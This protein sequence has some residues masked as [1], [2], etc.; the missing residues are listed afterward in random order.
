MP[1]NPQPLYGSVPYIQGVSEA[2]AQSTTWVNSAH[3]WIDI[4]D[5]TMGETDGKY[6]TYL[7][8][9]GSL[10]VFMFASTTSSENGFNR[11]KKVQQDLAIVSGYVPLP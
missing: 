4:E 7:S 1:G 2:Q 6:V 9:S 11:F 5:M 8:E 10:E 3:T